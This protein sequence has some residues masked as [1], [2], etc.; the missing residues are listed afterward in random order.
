MCGPAFRPADTS[1]EA[2]AVY[3][4][5]LRQAGPERRATMAAELTENLR[6]TTLQGIRV[7]HPEYTDA[8]IR[9]AF[10]R[11]LLGE[12]LFREVC[13]GVDVRP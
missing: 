8:Q 5:G 7:R 11:L 4:Q 12:R 2:W 1:E 6:R 9:Q 13:P 10:L 3:I